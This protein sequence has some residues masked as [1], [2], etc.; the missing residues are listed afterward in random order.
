[1]I[2]AERTSYVTMTRGSYDGRFDFPL[3]AFYNLRVLVLKMYLEVSKL[4]KCR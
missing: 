1:M 4:L 2:R 3:R